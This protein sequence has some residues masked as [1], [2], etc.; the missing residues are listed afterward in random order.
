MLFMSEQY[1]PFPNDK[2]KSPCNL[3]QDKILGHF[4]LA[5]HS[6]KSG[7]VKL[8]YVLGS[9]GFRDPQGKQLLFKE[10]LSVISLTSPDMY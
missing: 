2:S 4:G 7:P 1:Y 3:D 5:I 9:T 8:D 6:N 10:D